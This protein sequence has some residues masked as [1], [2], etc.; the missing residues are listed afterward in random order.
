MANPPF[1][2]A[3]LNASGYSLQEHIVWVKCVVDS[4]LPVGKIDGQENEVSIG[5]LHEERL[6]HSSE[7]DALNP[8]LDSEDWLHALQ[9]R[10]VEDLNDV[11]ISSVVAGNGSDHSCNFKVVVE[12]SFNQSRFVIDDWFGQDSTDVAPILL[13]DVCLCRFESWLD[14]LVDLARWQKLI[15]QLRWQ[16]W[17]L[18]AYCTAYVAFND[19]HPAVAIFVFNKSDNFSFGGHEPF[20]SLFENGLCSEHPTKA[21]RWY[22]HVHDRTSSEEYLVNFQMFAHSIPLWFFNRDGALAKTNPL[23]EF[24]LGFPEK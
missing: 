9:K 10:L 22:N 18:R 23:N 13:V 1:S 12:G 7:E 6:S 11:W 15:S 4:Y 3:S 19:L 5:S 20:D 21:I 8:S 2:I 24:K 17:V 16:G 14:E